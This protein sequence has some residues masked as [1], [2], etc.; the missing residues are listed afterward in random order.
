MFVY[1]N[2]FSFIFFKDI[3]LTSLYGLKCLVYQYSFQLYS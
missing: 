1:S 2:L 3:H